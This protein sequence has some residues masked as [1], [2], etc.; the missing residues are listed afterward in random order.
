MIETMQRLIK[1]K[2]DNDE[3]FH[4][5]YANLDASYLIKELRYFVSDKGTF[6]D[7][8][9]PEIEAKFIQKNITPKFGAMSSIDELYL[10][11]SW[12]DAIVNLIKDRMS[13]HEVSVI[14]INELT[15]EDLKIL[16]PSINNIQIEEFFKYRDGDVD[17]KIKGKKFKDAEDFKRVTVSELNILSDTEYVERM[18]SLNNAGLVI[19][20]AGKLYKVNSRG[21][22]NNAVYN[23]VAFID[24]PIKPIIKKPIPK[25]QTPPPTDGEQSADDPTGANS[26]QP[27]P[28]QKAKP[29]PTQLLLPRIVEVRLE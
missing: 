22:M 9:L 18:T 27:P 26:A 29:E 25:G 8:M 3:D 10:L 5:H 11:P 15:T 13:V 1:D 12:D 4:T 17:K 7:S 16:F 24:L 14:A 6:Q 19:D 23:L 20:T 28:G 21:S 2:N